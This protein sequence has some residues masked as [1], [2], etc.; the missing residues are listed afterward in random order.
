M[1]ASFSTVSLNKGMIPKAFWRGYNVENHFSLISCYQYKLGLFRWIHYQ[2][3]T[4]CMEIYTQVLDQELQTCLPMT[5]VPE[6]CPPV[7]GGLAVV[8]L[9]S[10]V[11]YREGA[12]ILCLR[13]HCRRLS[14]LSC[15]HFLLTAAC[16]FT[17]SECHIVS[18]STELQK[19]HGGKGLR[20]THSICRGP[21][22]GDPAK[23]CLHFWP[24][25]NTSVL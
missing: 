9:I 14:R 17:W 6:W 10:S 15:S 13:A 23:P 11:S 18:C 8:T 20:E 16:S 2:N 24:Y 1:L 19:G 12:G 21:E 25:R 22:W 7:E 3:L 4:S 5:A